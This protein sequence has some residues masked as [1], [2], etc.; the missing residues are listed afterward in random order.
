MAMVILGNKHN[1]SVS[2]DGSNGDLIIL[3]N[4]AKTQ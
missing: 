1:L 4:G 3:G 2:D